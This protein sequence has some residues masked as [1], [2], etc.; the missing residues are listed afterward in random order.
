MADRHEIHL[1]EK[2]YAGEPLAAR[3][4]DILIAEGTITRVDTL[5]RAV[6]EYG[7]YTEGTW[8]SREGKYIPN[9]EPG[10][11]TSDE[12]TKDDPVK[13]ATTSSKTATPAK[14]GAK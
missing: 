11:S 8:D 10:E 7:E 6:D 2:D 12:S 13:V 9:D 3:L 14:A 1:S 5:G 4:A